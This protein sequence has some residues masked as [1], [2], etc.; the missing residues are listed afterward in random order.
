[1]TFKQPDFKKHNDSLVAL[2]V[3][4]VIQETND[5]RTFRLD[6]S[7]GLLSPHKPGMFIK[8]CLNIKG[9]EVW[10]SFTISS[11][12]F[13]RERIDLTIKR[14]PQG[15]AGNFLFEH[16]G[17]GSELNIKG[18][19]GQFFYDQ[20]LHTEPVVLLCAGIGITPMMSI[21]RYLSDIKQNT[22][23][24]LFYGARTH[25]DII[26][27]QETRQSITDLPGFQYFLTLSQASPQWLGNCGR[28]SFDFIQAKISPTLMSRF[29][30]C[31]PRNFNQNFEEQLLESGVPQSLI[32]CEHFH[33][34]RK[35][36]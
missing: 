12:P 15:E 11:S 24:A 13:H 4:D 8:V 17:P 6:N 1:M 26:F 27:D 7:D 22:P 33:K 30:L 23:C 35:S 36:K 10:R 34:K 5:V 14:N 18:P 32:H 28:L 2:S 29:F 31:G 21:I 9:K 20:E 16:I 25:R 19:S 3:T